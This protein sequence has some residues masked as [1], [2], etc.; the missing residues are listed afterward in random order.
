MAMPVANV[1]VPEITSSFSSKKESSKH[2]HK[3]CEQ[4]ASAHN[5]NDSSSSVAS[6]GA[7][8]D[9]GRRIGC[10]AKRSRDQDECDNIS[11]NG[12]SKRQRDYAA[13]SDNDGTAHDPKIENHDSD[14]DNS[15]NSEKGII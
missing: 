4:S 7:P 6:P 14:A 9:D 15:S 3:R 13:Y 10:R 2:K 12:V 8:P 5:D 11:T 1:V